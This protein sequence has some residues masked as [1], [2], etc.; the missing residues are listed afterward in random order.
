MSYD[1]ID[2]WKFAYRLA[3]GSIQAQDA[4]F[5]N[6]CIRQTEMRHKS[7]GIRLSYE[8]NSASLREQIAMESNRKEIHDKNQRTGP[9]QSMWSPRHHP[10][11]WAMK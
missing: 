7:Q 6:T 1:I 5:K 4:R 9:Q 8:M 2:Q 10:F 3:I 11:D